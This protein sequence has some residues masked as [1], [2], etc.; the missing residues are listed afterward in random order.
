VYG[1]IYDL[2]GEAI[3]PVDIATFCSI[4]LHLRDPFLALHKVLPL[5]R[6]TLIVSDRPPRRKVRSPKPCMQFLPDFR[7][8]APQ[9]GWWR[10]P[11]EL[12]AEFAG[13]FGFEDVRITYHKQPYLG[14]KTRMYTLVA[15]R[16]RPAR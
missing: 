7:K 2:P 1:S 12:V 4:L 3:G 6:E 10:I 15:R 9:D 8:C 16:T 13:V 14:K 5:T 11:P